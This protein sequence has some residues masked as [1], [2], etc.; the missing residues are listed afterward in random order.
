MLAPSKTITVE[1]S[2]LYKASKLISEIESDTHLIDL[3]NKVKSRF[4]GLSDFIDALDLL[5]ILGKVD[6][7]EKNGVVK[8][9]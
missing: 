2:S 5:F 7:D 3:Y 6:F 4:S 1:E 9:A 8:V